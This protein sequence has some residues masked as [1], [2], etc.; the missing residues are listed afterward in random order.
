VTTVWSAEADALA[1]ASYLRDLATLLWP[2][3]AIVTIGRGGTAP[4]GPAPQGPAQQSQLP[5]SSVPGGTE[6]Y[7]IVPHARH[8]RLLVPAGRR[9]AAAAVAGFHPGRS[10]R[11]RL[12]SRGLAASLRT[13]TGHAILRDRLTVHG[14][15]DTLRS[16]LATVMGHG[17][18]IAIHI[19]PARANRKPVAQ[20]IGPDG[21]TIGYAKMGASELTGDLVRAEDAALRLLGETRLATVRVPRVRHRGQWRGAE[22]LVL[23]P[24]PTGRA[25]RAR[26]ALRSAAMLE[27]AAIGGL[28]RHALTGSPY[29]QD[30]RHGLAALGDRGAPLARSLDTLAARAGD[31]VLAFGAWHGDWTQW[32]M[33]PHGGTL[34]AWDWERFATGVPVGFDALH[35]HLQEAITAR[36]EP[37]AQAVAGTFL[38]APQLVQPFSGLGGTSYD[39]AGGQRAVKV[40]AALYL[41]QIARR[42]L[43]DRQDEAGA[44]LGRP[45]EWLLPGLNTAVEAL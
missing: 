10:A 23:E 43:Q 35:F 41:L 22:I 42:Y 9:A 18:A 16:H 15:A 3:P 37:P 28:R 32:N 6:E 44:H 33:A 24:L 20:L 29:L 13:G 14:A 17:L 45:A 8:P 12:L 5:P 25:T 30:L 11:A 38:A 1:R 34:L 31:T 2:P 36:H 4:Q 39:G 26:G 7:V 21:D 27:V 40:T 19:G